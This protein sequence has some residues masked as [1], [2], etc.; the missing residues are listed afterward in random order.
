M[1]DPPSEATSVAAELA[2]IASASAPVADRVDAMLGELHRLVP[3]SGADLAILDSDR[4]EF[5]T[6][7]MIGCSDRIRDYFHQPAFYADIEIAGMD[8]NRPP[9]CVRDLPVPRGELR[10]WADYL[11]P[12]GF[13]EGVGVTLFAPD[14]R[15]LGLLSLLTDDPRGPDDATRDFIG[16]LVPL[17]AN[18]IDPMRS[19]G[20]LARM[21]TDARAGVLLTRSGH[22]VALPG[23]SVEDP[24]LRPGSPV[25]AVAAAVLDAGQTHVP[26]LAPDGP[27]HVRV[28]VLACPSDVPRHLQAVVLVSP[29]GDLHGL[30]PRELE[31]LGLVI[32]GWTNARIARHAYITER[33]VATHLEHIL[34]KLA[35]TSRTLA[36]V[37]ALR[38]G[39]YVPYRLSPTR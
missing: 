6:L 25:L 31:M 28:T 39:L 12:A 4:R 37:R 13:R 1:A 32:E 21:V 15:H 30:T 23:L 19:V 18:A 11:E 29:S 38:L 20:A 16:T 33:T 5:E 2:Q 7:R 27:V 22:V 10:V 3:Y 24:L 8:R 17:I 34:A 35:V 26:F 9:M 36:A 14:G